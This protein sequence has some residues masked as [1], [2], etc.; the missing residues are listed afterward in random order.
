VD[1][2]RHVPV[3]A[4]SAGGR[5][6]GRGPAMIR[7]AVLRSGLGKPLLPIIVAVPVVVG[8]L[9][10]PVPTLLVVVLILAMAWLLVSPD[11]PRR[12]FVGGLGA[13]LIGY[14]FLGR[15]LSHAGVAPVYVGELV[16]G[17]GVIAL[18]LSKPV[19]RLDLVRL[20]LIAFMAWGLLQTVPYFGRYGVDALRDAVTWGYGFFA[21]AIAALVTGPDLLRAVDRYR[22]LIIPLLGFLLLSL[23]IPFSTFP[24]FPGSDV[25][26]VALKAGDAAV[27]L[28]G[29]AAFLLLGLYAAVPTRVPEVLVWLA[30]LPAAIVMGVVNRGGMGALAMSGLAVLFGRSTER[31]LAPLF[32]VL[33]AV[34]SV[35]YVDP[36]VDLGGH[37]TISVGQV[38]EN[39]TSVVGQTRDPSLEGTK[40]FRL[41]WWGKI[42]D[43]TVNGRYFWTGK[44]FGV[45]LAD[46]DGFQVYADHSLRAPHNGHMEILA[47]TGVPGFALWVALNLAW[48]A[49]VLRAVGRAR[50]LRSR[51]WAAVLIWLLVY[52]AAMMVDASFDPYLQ[53]PQGGIWFWA[54]I[55]AGLVAVDAARRLPDPPT[56]TAR[57]PSTQPAVP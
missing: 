35:V 25:P 34:V 3:A 2:R 13:L 56:A 43:Y 29:V 51:T 1:L 45:N 52:W 48:A 19:F 15:G 33:I 6:V 24:P 7:R 55:G 50:A 46:E 30:W 27:H 23:V 37:R 38:I 53:G 41:R 21:L 39:V 8:A 12:V 54:V 31:L 57:A 28:A 20:L 36:V 42:I 49:A 40:E 16:L 9:L 47:R 32:V 4:R 17:L 10:A 5:G 11:R 22:R 14:A 44:G 18:V 26:I